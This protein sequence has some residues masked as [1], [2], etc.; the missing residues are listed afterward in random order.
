MVSHPRGFFANDLC[1][2]QRLGQAPTSQLN[3]FKANTPP[4]SLRLGVGLDMAKLSLQ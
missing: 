4:A 1:K 2:L 3:S